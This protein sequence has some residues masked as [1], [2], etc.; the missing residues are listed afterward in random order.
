MRE[1]TPL[2]SI[3]VPVY[4]AAQYI[5]ECILS[6]VAQNYK[7]LE[8]IIVDDGS[9]DKSLQ[10]AQN[11]AQRHQNTTRVYHIANSG[12]SAA[13]NFGIE[14]SR[15]DYVFFVDADD[16][17]DKDCISYYYELLYHNQADIAI[18]PQPN[19]FH[20]LSPKNT[21][22]AYVKS[23]ACVSGNTAIE[24]MLYYKIVI[25]SWGK[26]FSK[27]IIDKYHIRFNEKL[28]YG[29]GFLFAIQCLHHTKKVAIGHSPVYNYRLSNS[30]S[31]MT[32]YKERL[33]KDSIASQKLIQKE[34]ASHQQEFQSALNYAYWHTCF[35]CLNTIIGAKAVKSNRETF[36][37]L[38]KEVQQ[39]AIAG[40]RSP[41]SKT[42]KLKS[43]LYLIAPTTTAK[44]INRFR[45]RKFTA[46]S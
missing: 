42:E 44:A 21:K 36:Q 28:A 39:G 22:K 27:K 11:I 12:V 1:K 10:I 35:D 3:I 17:L 40:L 20:E 30:N 15:G 46:N 38:R 29:E 7:N 5:Q 41:I 45:K 8:I 6:I 14:H 26:L 37:M 16:Y 18:V 43:A 33:T 24:K 13:R 4:N 23:T 9:T 2:I 25:S 19:K 32:N 31:V 34:L